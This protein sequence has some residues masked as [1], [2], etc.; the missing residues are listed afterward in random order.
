MPLPVIQLK[1]QRTERRRHPW[2]FDN[3]I[4]VG[5]DSD[6]K[7]GG[8]VQAADAN[9]KIQ[10]VGYFNQNSRIAFRYLTR[11]RAEEIDE[12]FWRHRIDAAYKYRRARYAARSQFPQAYR[13]VHGEADALPG[14]VVDVYGDFAVLQFLAL[15]L[16]PW[17]QEIIEAVADVLSA[18]GLYERS[19]SPI[20]ELEGLEQKTG[21]IWGAIPPEVLEIEDENAILLANIKHG[22]KTGLFLDQLENQ[23]AAAAEA[24]GREVL[25]CFSYTGLFGLRAALN[26]AQKVTDVEISESFN[27]LNNQQW[28]RNGLLAPHMVQTANVFDYLRELDAEGFRTDM[29]VLDP[30][31]FTKN[32]SSRE[33]AFRGYNEINRMALRMLRPGGI[34]VT[35]SC[36]HHLTIDEFISIVHGAGNDAKKG[37]KLIEQ[38]GQPPDHPTLLDAPESNYLKCLILAVS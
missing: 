17:R 28:Q 20:R 27:T 29:V 15:G 12:K 6:F 13:L 23:K 30:P 31:A 11:K 14:L 36:S 32:R 37:L 26:G 24:I 21:V 38:R 8:L 18:K 1:P 10:G 4:A 16:E 19:D 3:E 7:N 35:C 22:A 5:P 2:A 34:L 33:G 9:G 25:N